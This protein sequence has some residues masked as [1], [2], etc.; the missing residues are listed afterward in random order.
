MSKTS[1]SNRPV[2]VMA[3]RGTGALEFKPER[4][5]N[6]ESSTPL[7]MKTL[8]ED[9]RKLIEGDLSHDAHAR[10]ALANLIHV[11]T[12]AGG[13]RAKAVIA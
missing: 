2:G 9:A 12:S 10:A 1:D 5:P 8:V 3:K 6:R 7:K 4:G 11:G 13:A